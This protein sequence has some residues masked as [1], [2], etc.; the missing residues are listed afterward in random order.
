[1]KST[2]PINDFNLSVCWN[3]MI[4]KELAS[5]AMKMKDVDCNAAVKWVMLII[6]GEKTRLCTFRLLCPPLRLHTEVIHPS[7][8]PQGL[9]ITV[10]SALC[11]NDE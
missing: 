6:Y 1:M 11:Q 5:S 2:Q 7:T 8:A 4:G 9:N 3:K 10:H